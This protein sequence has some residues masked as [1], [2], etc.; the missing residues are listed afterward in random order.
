MGASAKTAF[1][2]T[3]SGLVRNMSLWDAAFFGLLSTGGAY[4]FILLYPLPQ[5][6][7]HQGVSIPALTLVTFAFSVIVYFVYAALGSAMPRAG[8]DF[9]FETRTITVIA[10]A[11]IVGVQPVL[12]ARL[13]DHRR[14][15]RPTPWG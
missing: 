14:I 12:L 15:R 13:P 1:T 7:K 10:L 3:A 9:V 5:Y 11:T 6:L 8:G 4:T 2:R